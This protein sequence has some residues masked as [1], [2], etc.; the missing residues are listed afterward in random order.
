MWHAAEQ[1]AVKQQHMSMLQ[2]AAH[3]QA[4]LQQP[5]SINSCPHPSAHRLSLNVVPE[6]WQQEGRLFGDL[7][8]AGSC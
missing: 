8:R 4:S 5:H 6:A 2:R 3:I 1:Q 7:C